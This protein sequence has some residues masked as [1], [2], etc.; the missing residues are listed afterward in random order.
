MTRSVRVHLLPQLFDPAEI[1]GGVAVI[2]DILRAST[3]ITHALANGA[4][5]VIP[6]GSV[7]DALALRQSTGAATLLGGERGG[8]K[9]DGFDFGNSPADYSTA[10][11]S[12]K[13]IGFTTTNGTRALLASQQASEIV[14]GCFANL[15]AVLEHVT[16]R[17]E[18]LHIVCAGTDGAITGE[19]VLFAGAMV[20]RL[21]EAQVSFCDSAVIALNHWKSETAEGRSSD[22]ETAMLS[23]QG[24]RNL[25]RLGY[26]KDIHTASQIDS[27][28]VVGIMEAEGIRLQR[29]A[30]QISA[31][32]KSTEQISTGE[33]NCYHETRPKKET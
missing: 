31:L 12:G 13:T 17:S 20:S 27:V 2:V 3:T 9:I 29:S 7:D 22:V 24:G 18:T 14:I 15:T 16:A 26:N 21:H 1:A 10:A 4:N 5:N 28:P 33:L 25:V 6:C 32:P 30:N 19:D 11:V 8:I 23:S